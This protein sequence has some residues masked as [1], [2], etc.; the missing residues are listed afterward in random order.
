MIFPT[1]PH[2]PSCNNERLQNTMFSIRNAWW[3]WTERKDDQLIR[4]TCASFYL[5]GLNTA[6]AASCQWRPWASTNEG[7]KT[8]PVLMLWCSCNEG[9]S[10][11]ES[12]LSK[13]SESVVGDLRVWLNSIHLWHCPIFVRG[14]HLFTYLSHSIWI[15]ER[16]KF[17]LTV[18]LPVVM[19]TY[20][21]PSG[22]R[23][24]LVAPYFAEVLNKGRK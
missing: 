2:S 4:K 13:P 9:N 14:S 12:G 17:S 5:F 10:L 8:T 1:R 22:L 6:L 11:D 23:L 7:H 15:T 3:I 18:W 20:L 21:E 19:L 24:S 16:V